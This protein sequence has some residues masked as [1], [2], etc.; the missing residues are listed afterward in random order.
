MRYGVNHIRVKVEGVYVRM[1]VGVV[2]GRG[3]E[4]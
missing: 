1:G 2:R 3:S 4:V